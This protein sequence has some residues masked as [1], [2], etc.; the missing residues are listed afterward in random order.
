MPIPKGSSGWHGW[1]TQTLID[2]NPAIRGR[3]LYFDKT[4][5][6]ELHL[7]TRNRR[8][9]KWFKIIMRPGFNASPKKLSK[10]MTYFLL[11]YFAFVVQG[12]DY[13]TE[14]D[15]VFLVELLWSIRKRN[16]PSNAE[17]NLGAGHI[18]IE[19]WFRGY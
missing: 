1:I 16:P 3:D 2:E 14:P 5:R 10:D 12:C 9:K 18:V 8:L 4:C 15:I 17:D 13:C 6:W 11:K 19:A 7:E